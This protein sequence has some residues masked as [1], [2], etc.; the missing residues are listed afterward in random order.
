MTESESYIYAEVG[1]TY[2]KFLDWREKI[3]GGYVAVIGGL[4]FGYSGSK[5]P[6]FQLVLLLAAILTSIA[7]WILNMRNSKFIMT[8]VDA[9][10]KVEEAEKKTGVYTE[11]DTLTHTRRL[12]HWFKRRLTH[13]LA[14]N[15][16][17]SG[18][19]VGSS[20][21][22]WKAHLFQTIGCC[23]AIVLF[24]VFVALI[25]LAEIIGDPVPRR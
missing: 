21:G 10:R 20:F 19:I 9:G 17:V 11:M 2:R 1:Q 16:L 12:T 8:C 15:L 22:L 3:I 6:D 18:V 23:A 7:F 13:G 5:N 4:G 14:V 25:L 24:I